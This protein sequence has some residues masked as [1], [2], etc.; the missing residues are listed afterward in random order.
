MSKLHY[1]DTVAV[2]IRLRH[3][4]HR[5]KI[6]VKKKK[7]IQKKKKKKKHSMMFG[8]TAQGRN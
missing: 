8:N 2:T 1:S 5:V 3:A 6:Q 7:K 4:V